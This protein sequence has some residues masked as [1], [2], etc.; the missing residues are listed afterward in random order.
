MPTAEAQGT[1][2]V[3]RDGFKHT[4]MAHRAATRR[5]TIKTFTQASRR[6]LIELM[7]RLSVSKTRATFLTLTF[8]GIPST[9]DAKAAFR[10]FTM[11]L[12][13]RY[14][15]VSGIWRL[16]YQERGSPHFHMILFD[17]PFIPQSSLQRAWE[18][19]TRES[20]SIV[21]IAFLR[22][23]KRQ[24]MYYVSKYLAKTGKPAA[25]GSLDKAAY[26]H[27]DES[28]EDEPGRFWGWI[29]RAE[30]PFAEWRMVEFSDPVAIVSLWSWMTK[31][32]EG[33]VGDYRHNARCYSDAADRMIDAL[34]VVASCPVLHN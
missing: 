33:K 24:A 23:G 34:L 2:L 20:C 18:E 3:F 10:R 27:A 14:P 32:T 29:N 15:R 17:L 21:H 26:Q 6:R 5:G 30:L 16:E 1:L 13:R 19:C 8:S 28:D 7:A 31:A 12:R 22:G 25:V 11:R 4:P 9:A